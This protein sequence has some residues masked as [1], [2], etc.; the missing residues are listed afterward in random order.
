MHFKEV[1]D[2]QGFSIEMLDLTEIMKLSNALPKSRVIDS[3]I[4]EKYIIATI[5]A[6][7]LCQ[8]K[9]VQ[10][11]RWIGIKKIMMDKAEA[12]SALVRAKEAGHKTAKEKEWFVQSDEVVMEL[13]NE[14]DKARVAKL[15][16]DNKVRYFSM[17]HYS[18]KAFITRDY[19]IEKSSNYSTFSPTPGY[20]SEDETESRVQS[21]NKKDAGGDM[22]WG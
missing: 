15:W 17:W 10:V 8:E 3:N 11:E 4:A 18:L 1:M 2:T 20:N 13:K 14:L 5:E 6:Q 21:V 12:E 16:L 22:D 7:D 9:I 19:N